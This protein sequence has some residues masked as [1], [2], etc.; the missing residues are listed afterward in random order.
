MLITYCLTGL[1]GR[2]LGY[3]GIYN[4][5]AVEVDTYSNFDELVSHVYLDILVFYNMMDFVYRT[6]MKITLES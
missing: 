2:G 5:L 1:A 6:I 3:E 4:A